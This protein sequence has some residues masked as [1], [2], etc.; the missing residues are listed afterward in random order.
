[1]HKLILECDFDLIPITITSNN[2][3][4]ISH[5][6]TNIFFWIKTILT[7]RFIFTKKDKIECHKNFT[8]ETFEKI[9]WKNLYNINFNKNSKT[10]LELETLES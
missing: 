4:P 1:L 10:L 6:N 9:L 3:E 7:N 2:L 5:N 8:K